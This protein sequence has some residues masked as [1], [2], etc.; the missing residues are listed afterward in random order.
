MTSCMA[1]VLLLWKGRLDELE[2]RDQR[3]RTSAVRQDLFGRY[4]LRL[5]TSVSAAAIHRPRLKGWAMNRRR[6]GREA[7]CMSHL[8]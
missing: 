6:P 8:G 1:T 2:L 3:D 5:S 7:V 4:K